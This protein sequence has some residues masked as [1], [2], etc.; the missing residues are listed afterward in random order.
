MAKADSFRAMETCMKETDAKE[1][2][3]A[4]ESITT[5]TG[6][7]TQGFGETTIKRGWGRRHGKMGRGLRGIM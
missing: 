5:V 7:R 4:G 6:R 1:R 2:Q 3:K